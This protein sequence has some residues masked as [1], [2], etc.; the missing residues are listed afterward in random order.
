V[1]R[2][3]AEAENESGKKWAI[4]LKRARLAGRQ[5]SGKHHRDEALPGHSQA[6]CAACGL[7]VA[8]ADAGKPSLDAAAEVLRAAG[9]V[10]ITGIGANQIDGPLAKG[11]DIVLYANTDFDHA[12]SV[13]TYSSVALAGA[14]LAFEAT[15]HSARSIQDELS[16]ALVDAAAAIPEWRQVID[17]LGWLGDGDS[18]T[19]FLARGSGIASWL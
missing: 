11:S 14:L 10:I 19:Y 5:Y 12:V 3:A 18:Y 15:G 9:P 16:R 13:S 4:P 7:T 17:R 6:A 1:F 2:S 8:F